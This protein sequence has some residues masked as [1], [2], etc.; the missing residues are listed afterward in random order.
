M[1]IATHLHDPEDEGHVRQIQVPPLLEFWAGH[2]S[3]VIVGDF[4]AIPSDPEIRMMLDA[5]LIDSFAEAG[6]GQGY[7][8]ASNELRK[9]IDYIWVSPDL[10]PSDVTIPQSTASDHLGVVV[11][12]ER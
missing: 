6:T 10:T 9:R 8:F 1:M 7:T 11:T 3:A 4:N 12:V 2:P 5:G